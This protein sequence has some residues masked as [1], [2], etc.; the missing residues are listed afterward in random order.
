MLFLLFQAGKERYALEANRVIEVLPL[1][2]IK[3]IPKSPAGVAGLINYRGKPVPVMDL[4]ELMLGHAAETRL[5]TRII[6][7]DYPDDRGETRILGLIAERATETIQSERSNFLE[8]G[9]S[10]KSAPYLGPVATENSRMIQRIEVGKLLPNSIR[11]L[12]FCE[13]NN[14]LDSVQSVRTVRGQKTGVD[15]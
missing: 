11:E 3:A 15:P 12:L 8:P 2:Q 4:T 13:A 10:V 1:V 6:L 7:V 5:T 14:A 9:V